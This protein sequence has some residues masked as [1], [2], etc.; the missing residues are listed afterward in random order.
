MG[1]GVRGTLGRLGPVQPS[2]TGANLFYYF[3]FIATHPMAR[4][5]LDVR[6]VLSRSVLALLC[7]RYAHLLVL[8]TMSR[9]WYVDLIFFPNDNYGEA[10]RFIF[11]DTI[12]VFFSLCNAHSLTPPWRVTSG[13]LG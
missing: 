13:M 9:N 11:F 1:R 3:L 12:Y 6:A 7:Q 4:P 5:Y 2:Q 8:F 10:G